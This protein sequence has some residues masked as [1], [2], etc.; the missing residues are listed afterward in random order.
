MKQKL[1][2]K[3]NPNIKNIHIYRPNWWSGMVPFKITPG[4]EIGLLN[5]SVSSNINEM[6]LF[7]L[8]EVQMENGSSDSQFDKEAIKRISIT[9]STKGEP[10]DPKDKYGQQEPNHDSTSLFI[11]MTPLAYR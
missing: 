5:S 1:Q 9:S 6:V 7:L 8:K 2:D 3:L 11:D 10:I 4:T